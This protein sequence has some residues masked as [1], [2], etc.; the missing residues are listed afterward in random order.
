MARAFSTHAQKVPSRS[1]FNYIFFVLFSCF[2]RAFVRGGSMGS[3]GGYWKALHEKIAADTY[4]R[5]TF[6][7]PS[8]S[9]KRQ[10]QGPSL[11]TKT[12]FRMNIMPS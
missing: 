7:A 12:R 6:L 3:L 2:Q 11:H 9:T 5:D 10:A 4:V 1:T 8:Y